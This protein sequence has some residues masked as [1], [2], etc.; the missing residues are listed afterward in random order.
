MADIADRSGE[1]R[2]ASELPSKNL[3]AVEYRDLPEPIPLRKVAGAS[4]IILATA[5]GSGELILWPYITTQ[6]GIGLLWLA[7][8][9]FTMQLFLN[10]EIE[11]YTL[12]TGETAVTGFTRFWKPWGVIFIIGAILPNLWPGWVTSSATVFTFTFGL[13]EGTVPVIAIILLVTIGLVVSLSPVVYQYVEKIEM[14]LVSIILVFLVVGIVIATN[15]SA[16]A[17]VVTEAPSGIASFPQHF[18]EIGIATLL[19][20]IAFA[21]AGGANN[22][23]Q[24]NYIRDK[25]LGMGARI[26]NIVSPITGEEE[27]EP[28][29]G[30]M[31]KTDEENMRRWR[32]WWKV[33]NQEQFFIFWLIGLVSLIALSV[34]AYSTIG[35]TKEVGTD[36]A[37]IRDE[38][39]VL[40]D[41]IAPW[42][43]SFFF[44]AA[45]IKLFSTNL[46][47]LDWVSRLTADS[48]KVSFLGESRFWSES[49]IYITVVWTMI[50][51]GSIIILSGIKP[52][53]LLVIAS[54]GGGV[55]MAFYSVMLIVLNRR[56]LPEQIRLG[57]YRL[58]VMVITA[59]FFVSLSVYLVYDIL[60]KL[61]GS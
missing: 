6:V 14:V 36:L 1:G 30:Y 53:V 60:S 49:K 35:V 38:G 16:W 50:V 41:V 39:D 3:P 23:V 4:V 25:G 52:L 8:L 10:M 54:S 58:V 18:A 26:P 28:G 2:I 29:I 48:L 12:A 33:A 9:G 24:S 5:L 19:G 15:G 34:L 56:A 57:G 21:G 11:R 37:F 61:L 13:S 7:A 40:R 45:T 17:S 59:V 46:G 44:L 27:A 42:F 51:I 55:V 22:L 47:I 31:M 20:A 32:G 43:A